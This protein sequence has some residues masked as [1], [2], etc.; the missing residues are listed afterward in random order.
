M[1]RNLYILAATLLLASML[2]C[3]VAYTSVA[4][5]T[6]DRAL[7]HTMGLVLLLIAL[8]VAMGGMLTALFEQ[9]ERRAEEKYRKNRRNE[10]GGGRI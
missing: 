2:S 10:R 9:A 5:S 6:G 3:G 8:L 1:G 4:Q 7:W